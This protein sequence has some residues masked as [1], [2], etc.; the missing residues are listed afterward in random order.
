MQGPKHTQK[1]KKMKKVVKMKKLINALCKS[2]RHVSSEC[3]SFHIAP[4][5]S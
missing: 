5:C 2:N 1:G 3:I 4:S